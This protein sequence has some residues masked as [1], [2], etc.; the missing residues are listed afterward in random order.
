MKQLSTREFFQILT[1]N[2]FQFVRQ[3][4]N[5]AMWRRGDQLISVPSVKLN[6]MMARRFIREYN[7]TIE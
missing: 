2:G 3:K 1:K 4:G 6:I 7:L 5:H